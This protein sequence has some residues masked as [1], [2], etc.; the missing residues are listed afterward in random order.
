MFLD[1]LCEILHLTKDFSMTKSQNS[2]V[3]GPNER[4]SDSG[5]LKFVKLFKKFFQKVVL[6][7][8]TNVTVTVTV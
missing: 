8:K 7:K 3:L 1:F 6:N 4:E 5:R 2:S